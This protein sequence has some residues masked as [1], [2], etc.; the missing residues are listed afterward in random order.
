VLGGLAMKR[1]TF[2]LMKSVNKSIVLNKI[3]TSAPIS[4][5]QIAKETKLTP[6]TVSGIVRE[7]LDQG[8][9]VEKESG[10]SK[11]GRR[12]IMLQINYQAFSI[13]GV[14]VG[15]E[16]IVAVAT[17]LSGKI[18]K[19]HSVDLPTSMDNTLFIQLLKLCIHQ[20]DQDFPD[21]MGPFLGIGVAMHGA[22]DT[23]KGISL[24][25]PNLG[26]TNIPIK[27]ELEKEFDLEVKVENDARLMALGESWF[28][29]HGKLDSMI[30]VN[31]GRGVGGGV[32]INGEL[33]HGTVDI[34]GELG[35]MVIDIHGDTCECG[36]RGCL[37]TLTTGSA[38]ARLAQKKLEK[39]DQADEKIA[40][41]SG[42][43]VYELAKNNDE[44]SKNVLQKTG[45]YIGIGLINLIHIINPDKIVLG[46][47]VMN[48]EEFIMPQ[49]LQTVETGALTKEA[50]E[51]EIVVTQLGK[52]ATVLGAIAQFLVG[53]YE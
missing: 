47:G 1:G 15:P 41:L 49:I 51:T 19:R 36:N 23:E 9:V 12:P 21:T 13:I 27:E 6:P 44:L 4:R 10:K 34:A 18:L 38:I 29:G 3:R 16:R 11:G 39:Y 48:S 2:K 31:I 24:V 5:A 46:G 35:H 42:K 52:D 26:L 32:I 17:D 33:Y 28:G 30:V 22:V 50:G 14:D 45:E 43:D 40:N 7:F 37:Q 25:T 20:L 8:I 53:V